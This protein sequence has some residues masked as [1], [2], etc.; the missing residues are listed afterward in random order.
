MFKGAD[1]MAFDTI[2][3]WWANFTKG[4]NYFWNWK[5]GG[6]YHDKLIFEEIFKGSV[7]GVDSENEIGPN[8]QT[9]GI[10]CRWIVVRLT[11]PL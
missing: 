11:M 1:D 5:K 3:E 8:Q 9:C 10:P 2:V 6:N 4:S 7:E